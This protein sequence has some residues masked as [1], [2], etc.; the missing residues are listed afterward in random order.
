MERRL[1]GHGSIVLT[2]NVEIVGLIEEIQTRSTNVSTLASNICDEVRGLVETLE[3]VRLAKASFLE[4][5]FGWLRKM[6]DAM[7]DVL[8]VKSLSYSA[9]AASILNAPSS[10]ARAAA[11][12]CA[13]R[14]GAYNS[15]TYCTIIN[16]RLDRS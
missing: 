12:V 13:K 1:A 6:F 7:A 11:A 4:W 9:K 2:G 8:S 15:P 10:L 5:L 14:D 3:H 16:D